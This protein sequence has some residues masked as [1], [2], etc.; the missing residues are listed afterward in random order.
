MPGLQFYPI[1]QTDFSY[2]EE[3][4]KDLE[5]FLDHE[6][7]SY[8]IFE[9]D[10]D[11]FKAVMTSLTPDEVTKISEWELEYAGGLQAQSGNVENSC[12]FLIES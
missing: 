10:D 5:E 4:L 12:K 11:C 1:L 9:D 8:E 3:E 2:T 7:I 6:G